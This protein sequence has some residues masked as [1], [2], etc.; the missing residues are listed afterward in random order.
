[1]LFFVTENTYPVTRSP[2]VFLRLLFCINLA[3]QQMTR[4][5]FPL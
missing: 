3:Q 1:V 4:R 2:V 5:Q